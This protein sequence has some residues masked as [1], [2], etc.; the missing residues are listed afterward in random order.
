MKVLVLNTNESSTNLNNYLTHSVVNGLARNLG[1]ENV[2]TACYGDLMAR[3]YEFQPNA[4]LCI[5]G[6]H[7]QRDVILQAKKTGT[8]IV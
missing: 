7:V 2:S 1:V 3:L 4:L 6:Q 8:P 5:D